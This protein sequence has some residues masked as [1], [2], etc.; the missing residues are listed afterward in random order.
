MATTNVVTIEDLG[1]EFTIPEGTLVNTG[2][3]SYFINAL[4][5]LNHM[6]FSKVDVYYNDDRWDFGGYS[7]LNINR[8]NFIFTFDKLNGEL[9][10]SLKNYVALSVLEQRLKIQTIHSYYFGIYSYFMYL[11]ANGVFAVKDASYLILKN[12]LEKIRNDG[13]MKLRL[14][15]IYIKD[16]YLNYGANFPDFDPNSLMKLFKH[17]SKRTHQAYVD[18]HK[19]ADIP[20]EYYSRF[21]SACVSMTENKDLHFAIRGYACI[22][23]ILSQTGLRIGEL[24]NLR[25]HSLKTTTAP[26]G[27]EVNYLVYSTWKREK[28]NNTHTEVKTFVNSLCK[29]AFLLLVDLYQERRTALGLDY[30]FMGGVMTKSA[31]SFPISPAR[32]KSGSEPFFIKMDELD[33]LETINLP[34]QN[35]PSLSTFIPGGKRRVHSKRFTTPTYV[36]TITRPNTQGF[37]FYVCSELHRKGVSLQYV[38]KFMSHLSNEMASY[39]VNPKTTPQEDMEYSLNVLKSIVT[40]HEKVLGDFKGLSEKIQEYITSNN[41]NIE[42]DLDTICEQLALKIPIRRKGGG[43]CIK[44]SML[45]EC[46]HDAATNDFYCAYGVCPNIFHFYYMVDIT[47]RQCKELEQDIGTNRIREMAFYTERGNKLSKAEKSLYP[48]QIQKNMNMLGTIANKRLIPELDELRNMISKY[49]ASQICEE[50]PDLKDIIE[51]I[52]TIE[53]EAS[54]WKSLS[55]SK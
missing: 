43:V 44:S 45:R 49:G 1:L 33:L 22:Y 27:K 50:H 7:S 53:K 48:I 8:A 55:K 42:T 30:L 16:F 35:D 6:P 40:G 25:T 17:G 14:N 51:N 4:I 19:T 29:K 47:Y 24:L 31:K 34:E 5:A 37:R 52:D 12:Y 15:K 46:G 3:S 32:F 11:E 36:A 23:T 18:N 21:V 54:T 28:G 13:H 39:H 41:L 38:Q 2:D 20:D 9:K 26:D 10:N